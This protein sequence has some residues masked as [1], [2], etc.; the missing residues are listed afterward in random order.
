MDKTGA[1]LSRDVPT[2]QI[3]Y[4]AAVNPKPTTADVFC[5]EHYEIQAV[6]DH[7]G[8][9]GNYLYKV[10]WKGYDDPI[11]HTWEPVESFDSTKHIELYWG[12]RDGAQA[13]DEKKPLFYLSNMG[14]RTVLV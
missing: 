11:E 12:R 10:H 5:N 6:L 9:P 4:N 14:L 13:I 8:T 7:K 1:L 2:H 3:V